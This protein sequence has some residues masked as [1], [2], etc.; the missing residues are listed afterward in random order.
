M[1]CLSVGEIHSYID[2]DMPSDEL[3]RIR[4]HLESC[5]RCRAAEAD[6]RCLNSAAT[7]LPPLTSPP[8]FVQQ[9]M[10]AVFPLRVPFHRVL[11]AA[12]GGFSAIFLFLLGMFIVSGDNLLNF[13]M[14]I[15]QSA[16]NATQE[17]I[18][19][20]A[21]VIKLLSIFIKVLVQFSGFL[22][23]KLTGMANLVRMEI[24]IALIATMISIMAA[25]VI[26]KRRKHLIGNRYE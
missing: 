5:P 6:L 22:L 25:L 21:K 12:A 1:R 4:S 17:I 8:N 11:L 16:L 24:Q 23:E 14:N 10:A 26:R 7:S 20:T 19:V 3:A 15:N 13:L 2:A 9:I 18:V